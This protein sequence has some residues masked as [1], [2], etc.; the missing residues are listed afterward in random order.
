[1]AAAAM[2]HMASSFAK[3]KKFKGV[4]FRRWQKKMHFML[5]S[6]S[7]VYVLTAPMPEDG[8]ENPTVEQVRKRAKWDNND[9]VCR[10]LI[11]N[12]KYMAEDASSKKF[13]V[14]NFTNYKMTD[15]RPVLKQYN[16]LLGILGRFTQHNMNMDESIKAVICALR[17]PSELRI[18]TSQ[19]ATMLMVLQLSIWWSITTP[20]GNVSNRANAS[21][22]K[23]SE[24]G[25]SNPLKGQS[26]FNKSHQIYYVTYVSEAF[27]VQDDDVAWWVDSGATVHVCKDRCWFKT[28]E[29]LNDGSILHMGNESTAFVHERGCVDLRFSSGKVVSLLNVLHVPNIRKNLVSSSVLNNCGYKQ[30]IESNK[31]VLSK[32]GVFIGFGYLSNHMFRL[33]IVSDNIGSAFMSTSKL[34]DSILWHARLG[35]VHF[36]RMQDMSKD[37]LIPAFDMDTEKC[38]TCMLNKITKK[39]FQNVKRETKVL[40]LIHNNLCDLHATPSLGFAMTDKGVV[41]L[42]DPKLKTLGE[43]GIEC[44][45]VGYAEHS[46]AFCFYVIEPNDSV[47]INSIIESKDAI[48]DE[49]R[50]SSIPRPSQRSLVKG[51]EDIGGSVVSERV[52]NEIVQQSEPEL[53]K[54]KRHRKPKDFRP[55]FQLYL[56]EGTRDEVSDQH[57]Y[58]FNVEDDPK[59][60]DEA[61]KSQ[62]VAFWK[63]AINNEMDS[64]MGNN[65]WVLT[66]LP[67]GCRPLGCKWIF[68]RKLKVDGTIEKFK[69]RLV[70]HGFKQKSGIDYFN[71]YAP[72]ARISTIRLLIAM[73]SIH[74]LIIHQMDMKTT[75]LNG[76]LEE[77]FY[78][79]Q[80]LGFILPGN[81]NKVCKLVKSLYGLKQAPKQWHQKFDKVVLSNGYL[82]N[83]ADKCVYSKFD[84]SGIF[85]I[86]VLHE[87]RRASSCLAM[88]TS[89]DQVLVDPTKKFLLSR[90]S[91]KDIGEDDVILGIRIKYE[92]N[93]IVISQSRYTEKVV[94]QLKYYRVISCLMYAMTCT[95]PDIAFVVGKL[96]RYSN[97]LKSSILRTL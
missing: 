62:D 66:D 94:S 72:V 69:A 44:I 32:H 50:F 56:I 25:S 48:F 33:N 47:A 83:Q 9:Y 57:S 24:D 30:V 53:R 40:E 4:D 23:G 79:N 85:V 45:F 70:T 75:F 51:T 95:R 28:Y 16:E 80:P 58:C 78:M 84:E 19:R 39:P 5:S 29:S 8:G 21:S 37:G 11:R 59:T 61:M 3:L 46:K 91:M 43:R 77:E 22:T 10:G 34:N 76:E 81:E 60:F 89:T 38:Q 87:G 20:L 97:G 42:P 12:A 35:H 55:E 73:A 63:E 71:T 31:F 49:H 2:K 74:S 90:F 67:P 86:K 26:M 82:L 7:V 1:M 54:S 6:M 92:S 17:N 36:K 93:T 88:K 64:I 65:T 14:S 96:S 15:S 27:F 18:L 68:K 41:R 13:L 52:T